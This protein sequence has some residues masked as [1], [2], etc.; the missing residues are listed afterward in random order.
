M[1][2]F[3]RNHIEYFVSPR[4]DVE[5]ETRVSCEIPTAIPIEQDIYYY[6]QFFLNKFLVVFGAVEIHRS[7][8]RSNGLYF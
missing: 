5:E 3:K 4:I 8:D 6:E 2:S 1:A 7:E